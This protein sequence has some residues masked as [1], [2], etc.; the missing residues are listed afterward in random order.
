MIDITQSVFFEQ[1]AMAGKASL[2]GRKEIRD[3]PLFADVSGVVPLSVLEQLKGQMERCSSNGQCTGLFAHLNGRPCGHQGK[4]MVEAQIPLHCDDFDISWLL[5][6]FQLVPHLL[7]NPDPQDDPR[8]KGAIVGRGVPL[9]TALDS[10]PSSKTNGDTDQVLLN[11]SLRLRNTLQHRR[12]FVPAAAKDEKRKTK[13][14]AF[15]AAH[16][17][18][19]Y[20]DGAI[21]NSVIQPPSN[22]TGPGRPRLKL[23]SRWKPSVK[24]A[25]HRVA[26]GHETAHKQ[27]SQQ[28]KAELKRK[29]KE[30][31]ELL[32]Q[33]E[34]D[35]R[36]QRKKRKRDEGGDEEDGSESEKEKKGSKGKGSKRKEEGNGTEGEARKK[37]RK[38]DEDN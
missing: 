24:Y 14:P 1:T 33:Q 10:S 4:Q 17:L 32:L 2:K 23:R 6:F 15:E 16:A 22:Q 12:E 37:R 34:K 11:F 13:R 38:V 29:K 28:E 31:M 26:S 27:V 9:P 5:P 8:W 20:L 35:K 3:D 30:E 21:R 18:H 7:S 19:P 36:L 25:Y